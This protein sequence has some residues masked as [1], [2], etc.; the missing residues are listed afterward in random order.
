MDQK[1]LLWNKIPQGRRFNDLR[2]CFERGKY[3]PRLQFKPA[4]DPWRGDARLAGGRQRRFRGIERSGAGGGLLVLLASTLCTAV[5]HIVGALCFGRN[6]ATAAGERCSARKSAQLVS[7]QASGKDQ[8]PINPLLGRG[9]MAGGMVI[10]L[11]RRL[12]VP[13]R[14]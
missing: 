2:A 5:V 8:E 12:A 11:G 1:V 10:S 6:L 7:E 14:R 3:T 9:A 4:L 13:E